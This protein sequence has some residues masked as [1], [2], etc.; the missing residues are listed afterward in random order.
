MITS[1]Y[2][3]PRITPPCEHP[4]V[5]LRRK[6]FDRI[7]TNMTLPECQ[8]EYAL[9]Q[10]LCAMDFADFETP[11]TTGSYHSRLCIV[12]EA[13]ALRTLLNNDEAEA[14]ALIQVALRLSG[15]YDPNSDKLMKARFGG[16][17]VH[18]CAL[19]YDWLYA[20]MTE[21]E[22]LQIIETPTIIT[23]IAVDFIPRAIPS[24]IM[25]AEPVSEELASFWVGL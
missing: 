8:K 4:R 22:K 11:L 7:R 3:P 16:H 2:R 19:C 14:K 6:D 25:V 12:L 24:I 21:E 18:T 13:K 15:G 10:K 1:P 20:W 9:W 5:M 17:I 23:G